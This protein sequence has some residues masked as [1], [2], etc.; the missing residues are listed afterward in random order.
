MTIEAKNMTPLEWAIAHKQSKVVQIL[1]PLT[2]DRNAALKAKNAVADPQTIDL[3]EAVRI[4][5]VVGIERAAAAADVDIY[6]T[7]SEGET[8][9]HK[10]V[11]YDH[12]SNQSSVVKA[13]INGGANKDATRHGKWTP[14]HLAAEHGQ[15]EC[16]KILIA[17]GAD[18]TRRGNNGMTARDI[19]KVCGNGNIVKM[20]DASLKK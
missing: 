7:N 12:L 9:L 3:F 13:L 15:D 19:A 14:L 2:P 1:N 18:V 10:A 20:L 4:G 17:A 11:L 5:D 16:A 6:I 8:P